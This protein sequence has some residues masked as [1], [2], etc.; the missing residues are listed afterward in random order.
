MQAPSGGAPVPAPG[1]LFAGLS[2]LG[3]LWRHL[4]ASAVLPHLGVAGEAPPMCAVRHGFWGSMGAIAD[5]YQNPVHKA[6]GE[7]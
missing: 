6:V 2:W 3:M 5:V 4:P 7:T 1:A